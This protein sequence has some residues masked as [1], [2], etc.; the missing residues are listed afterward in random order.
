MITEKILEHEKLGYNKAF[1]FQNTVHDSLQFMPM[2]KD[3]E[4]CIKLISTNMELPCKILVNTATGSNGL[5]VA[6]ET[7]YGYNWANVDVE[8][9][10][11]WNNPKGMREWKT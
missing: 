11:G 9:I 6:V 1:N 8:G 5:K 3:L 4:I 2:E 10:E 7:S